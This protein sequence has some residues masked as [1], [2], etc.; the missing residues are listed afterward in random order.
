[1]TDFLFIQGH[2]KISRENRS[3]F[4]GEDDDDFDRDPDRLYL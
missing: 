3:P 1:M 4:S 2:I